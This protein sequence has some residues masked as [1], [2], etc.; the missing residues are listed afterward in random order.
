MGNSRFEIPLRDLLASGLCG[1][2][3]GRWG[4]YVAMKNA[5]TAAMGKTSDGKKMLLPCAHRAAFVQRF[6][7]PLSALP[8]S[9]RTFRLGYWMITRFMLQGVRVRVRGRVCA[10]MLVVIGGAHV[11][12]PAGSGGVP[13]GEPDRS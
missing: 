3:Q 9:A 12:V 2:P 5:L 4:K 1:I 13:V 11:L 10:P 6:T 7:K 8:K